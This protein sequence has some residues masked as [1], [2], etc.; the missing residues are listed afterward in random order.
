MSSPPNLPPTS[1]AGLLNSAPAAGF[2]QPFE[3]LEACHDR[4][5]RM[6]GLLERLAAHLPVHGC[7]AQAAQAARDVMRYF[8]I[9]A[10]AH[11]EDE[12]HH[13]LPRLRAAGDEAFAAQIEQEHHELHRQW[14]G[15]RR[16]L[17]EVAAGTWVGSGPADFV[18][19]QQYA[20]LY[21]AHAASEEAL[22]FPAVRAGLDD[23]T[24]RAMGQEMAERRGA[25]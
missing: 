9:A 16:T 25:R 23:E 6:L 20:A 14:A 3:M 24:L 19:W 18:P 21:R 1:T 13:V 10:P 12:E 11:H 7:D 5:R 8:D 2:D 15:L 17:A 22:A 4:V